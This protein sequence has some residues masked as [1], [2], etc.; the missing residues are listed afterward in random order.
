MRRNSTAEPLDPSATPTIERTLRAPDGRAIAVAEWG[1]P[2][3]DPVFFLHGM[4]GS[5][6]FC[7]SVADTRAMGVRLL[8]LDRPG[9]G[10][11]DPRPGRRIVDGADDV[12]TVADA[13]GI[14]RYAVIGWSS[15]G[16]YA[17]A[18]AARTPTRVLAVACVAGDAPLGDGPDLDVELPASARAR[19]EAIRSGDSAVLDE[20]RG[21][22][23][24]LADDPALVFGGPPDAEGGP[25]ARIRSVPAVAEALGG[26]MA[27][28]FRQGT[29]GMV[30]DWAATALPWGFDL[31]DV[32]RPTSIWRGDADE[33]SSAAHSDRLTAGIGGARSVV[34]PGAGHLI[35]VTHW[36]AILADVH[37]PRSPDAP[38][39]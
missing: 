21:R 19:V 31:G 37:A 17:I 32:T 13:L 26:M 33:L 22:W 27:E 36:A 8:A 23:A 30:D 10:R 29:E 7:P 2:G 5:R 12:A 38:G 24:P 14:A 18:C 28:A 39:A 1:D 15:G 3:G 4:P 35:V 16:P 11:S 34:V 20:L 9:Y 25:D 6:R